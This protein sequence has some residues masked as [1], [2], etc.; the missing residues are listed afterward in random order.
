MTIPRRR[1]L[2]LAAATGASMLSPARG[3]SAASIGALGLDATHLGLR[4]GSPDD[5]SETLQRAI[6]QAA[7]NRSPLVLPPGSYRAANIHLPSGAQLIGVRGGSRLVLSG[8]SSLLAADGADHV[9][10]Y[11]LVLDGVKLPLPERRGLLHLE[12]CHA[13]RVTDCEV[14]AS[15]GTGVFC[16]GVDGEVSGTSIA[17]AADVA[18]LSYDGEGL[19]IARNTISGAGNSGILVMR[20]RDGDDGTIIVDNRVENIDNRSGGDGQYGNGINAFRAANVIVR[21]NRIR[22]C[23]YS[24]VRGNSASNIHIEGNAIS[25]A[26]EVAI[27][28][29]FAFEGAVIAGNTVDGAETGVSVTN[30]NDGGRL[31]VVQ[32]N[33]FRN[34]APRPTRGPDI[35]CGVGIHIEADTAVSGNVVENAAYAGITIGWGPYLRDVAVTAN[36]VRKS[37]IGVIVSVV[38]GASTTVVSDNV[39]SGSERGAI[40]GMAWGRTVTGDLAKDGAGSYAHL[41]LSGNRVR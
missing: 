25:H 36:V 3:A 27:Y 19:T 24:G 6:E 22:N 7:R 41:T 30:F 10:L 9:T 38:P 34:L 4:P 5:Q 28:S 33:I 14:I 31:A 11:G 37:G 29:E 15:G 32:G 2:A 39:I 23:A 12:H 35:A 21:G 20:R 1:F 13:L 40:I 17:G 8:G 16:D 18:L 26:G